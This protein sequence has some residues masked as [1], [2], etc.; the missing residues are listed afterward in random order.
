[1]HEWFEDVVLQAV[2]TTW[3]LLSC[4]QQGSVLACCPAV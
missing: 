1:M 3:D 4:K 2:L